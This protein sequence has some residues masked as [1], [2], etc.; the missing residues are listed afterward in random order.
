MKLH[1]VSMKYKLTYEYYIRSSVKS[2]I[3]QYF[4]DST[5]QSHASEWE[6]DLEEFLV[7]WKI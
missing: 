1:E 5:T 2:Y 6:N 4:F 7:S 3:N